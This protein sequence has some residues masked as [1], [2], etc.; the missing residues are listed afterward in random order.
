[1]LPKAIYLDTEV[2][3]PLPFNL[4]SAALTRLIQV[5]KDFE[6][7]IYVPDPVIDELALQ[8]HSKIEGVKSVVTNGFADLNDYKKEWL[9][10]TRRK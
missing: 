6:V 8:R 2:L 5:C 3:N 7:Q 4:T 9:F 10:D 1:M